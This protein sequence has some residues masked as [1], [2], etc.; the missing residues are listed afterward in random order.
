MI[1]Y[2]RKVFDA[3]CTNCKYEGYDADFETFEML[4][5]THN[6]FHSKLKITCPNC[7]KINTMKLKEINNPV[8]FKFK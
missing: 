6:R 1:N 8:S 2:V 3:I 7:S 5:I 4:E